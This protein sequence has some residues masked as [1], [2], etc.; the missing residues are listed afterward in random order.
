MTASDQRDTLYY[1]GA[2]GLCQRSVR[3]FKR[4]DWFGRL[5]YEDMHRVDLGALGLTLEMADAGIPMRTRRGAV[6]V[7]YPAVRR[8]LRQT[9]LGFV[10]A[11]LMYVPGIS[12]AGRGVYAHIARNRNTACKVRLDAE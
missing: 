12:H 5:A 11:L 7:G 1:D 4:L 3:W 10:P 8:A 2:C 6:L 9:V